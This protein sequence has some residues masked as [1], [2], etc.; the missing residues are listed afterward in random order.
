VG[1]PASLSTSHA[2]QVRSALRPP[3]D[4][5]L[6]QRQV[7][8]SKIE[9]VVNGDRAQKNILHSPAAQATEAALGFAKDVVVALR[10]VTGQTVRFHLRGKTHVQPAC[11]ICSD[12]S[13]A[14]KECAMTAQKFAIISFEFVFTSEKF[15]VYIMGFVFVMFLKV[16]VT[17]LTFFWRGHNIPSSAKRLVQRSLELILL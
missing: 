9:A 8:E 13:G 14:K 7:G 2:A 4:G 16:S 17:F 1:N 11:D 12:K 6:T 10:E 5:T 15:A 3:S